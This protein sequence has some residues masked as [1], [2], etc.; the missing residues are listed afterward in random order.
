MDN[1][2]TPSND[3]ILTIDSEATDYG[4][5]VAG[6]GTITDDAAGTIQKASGTGTTALATGLD[7]GGTLSAATTIGDVDAGTADLRVAAGTASLDDGTTL[8]ARLLTISGGTLG[9]PGDVR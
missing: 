5:A 2:P 8:S 3:N 7:V 9:G 4:A 6:T 1:A